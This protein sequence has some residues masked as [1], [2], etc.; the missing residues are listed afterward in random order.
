MAAQAPDVDGTLPSSS[1]ADF[2]VHGVS[3]PQPEAP[4]LDVLIRD[5]HVFSPLGLDKAKAFIEV[6]PFD[7]THSHTHIL[8]QKQELISTLQHCSRFPAVRQAI[9]LPRVDYS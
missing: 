5:V 6:E 8:L 9:S 7:F 3:S 1:L 2:K 4:S